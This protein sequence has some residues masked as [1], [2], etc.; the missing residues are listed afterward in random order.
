MVDLV[1]FCFG[2]IFQFSFLV[3]IADYGIVGSQL[4]WLSWMAVLALTFYPTYRV[5]LDRRFETF[6]SEQSVCVRAAHQRLVEFVWFP[7]GNVSLVSAI[8]HT[9]SPAQHYSHYSS[10]TLLQC[11]PL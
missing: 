8:S 1:I 2:K 10:V 11:Q 5:V 3:H 7:N 4:L 6:R 9:S